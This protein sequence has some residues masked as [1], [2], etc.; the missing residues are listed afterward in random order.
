MA[1]KKTTK[2]DEPQRATIGQTVTVKRV[3]DGGG[4]WVC[5]THG[6]RFSNNFSKDSHI[7]A[8]PSAHT[9]AWFCG[10]CGTLQVP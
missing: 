10:V 2:D 8:R 5:T 6:I 9:R 4:G 3:R 1:K 7:H